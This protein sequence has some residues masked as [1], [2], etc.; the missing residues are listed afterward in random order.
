[1]GGIARVDRSLAL[2]RETEWNFTR[3][4]ALWECSGKNVL[5]GGSNLTADAGLVRGPRVN[6]W[7]L[8]RVHPAA[9]SRLLFGRAHGAPFT[10][11]IV[12]RLG[13]FL[14]RA[15]GLWHMT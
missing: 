10:G 9:E 6:A 3:S 1:V 12:I 15:K 4:A 13:S 5:F 11:G 7:V 8:S 2:R 14:R